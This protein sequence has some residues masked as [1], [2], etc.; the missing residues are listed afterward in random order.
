VNTGG[1]E[2]MKLVGGSTLRNVPLA[3]ALILIALVF[4]GLALALTALAGRQPGYVVETPLARFKV[5]IGFSLLGLVA[6][7]F[8]L[9]FLA[10]GLVTNFHL[11]ALIGA[12]AQILAL[13]VGIYCR[14]PA[15]KKMR[16]PSE[17][18]LRP[19]TTVD[20]RA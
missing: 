8:G 3:A 17:S 13:A 15:E 1:L 12:V 5:Y 2:A 11:A 16:A 10:S 14:V 18:T 9:A 6:Y 7:S 4:G 19:S 20:N